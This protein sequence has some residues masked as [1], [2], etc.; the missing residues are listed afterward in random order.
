M[1]GNARHEFGEHWG[2]MDGQDCARSA[3]D[4]PNVRHL[5]GASGGPRSGDRARALGLGVLGTEVI[6]TATGWGPK[7]K[8]REVSLQSREAVTR[9]VVTSTGRVQGRVPRRERPAA[10]TGPEQPG[11]PSPV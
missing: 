7:P 11:T 1:A 8:A 10:P 3:L 2:S 4:V 6:A 9:E 5:V